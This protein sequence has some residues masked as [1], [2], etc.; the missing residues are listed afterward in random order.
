MN[1]VEKITFIK[2]TVEEFQWLRDPVHCSVFDTPEM[3]LRIKLATVLA[4]LVLKNI[5]PETI[6]DIIA[7]ISYTLD[8]QDMMIQ[9][10]SLDHYRDRW[11]NH[12]NSY[13]PFIEYRTD[14]KPQ[15]K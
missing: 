6:I 7:E 1:V 13:A 14:W 2:K 3:L 9:D 10:Q 12:L 11:K 15:I 4:K 8:M 5:A